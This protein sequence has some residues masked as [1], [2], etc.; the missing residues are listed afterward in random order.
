MGDADSC[1]LRASD[2]HVSFGGVMALA[3]VSLELRAGEILGVIGPNSAGKTTLLNCLSGMQKPDSG[4]VAGWPGTDMTGLQPHRFAAKGVGRTFQ[5][6][7]L[8]R[9]GSVLRTFSWGFSRTTRQAS[10]RPC[11][12]CRGPGVM[13]GISEPRPWHFSRAWGSR[14]SRLLAPIILRTRRGAWWSSRVLA[15]HPSVIL[16]DEPT[17]GM[18]GDSRDAVG[19]LL[20]GIREGGSTAQIVIEHDMSFIRNLCDRLIVINFGAVLAAGDPAK[21]FD[22]PGVRR[23]YLGGAPERQ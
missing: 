11:G 16:L 12:A 5:L 21:V 22:D 1:A 19:K 23:S 9:H 14:N 15:I 3:G 17:S 4:T 20:A 18:S 7:S 13:S 2:I 10:P 6:P 8:I